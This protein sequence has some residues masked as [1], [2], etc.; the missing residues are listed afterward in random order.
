MS[1]PILFSWQALKRMRGGVQISRK[2][3]YI[4]GF[5]IVILANVSGSV[6]QLIICA[7]GVT[8][9][10]YFPLNKTSVPI[11]TTRYCCLTVE[12]DDA[13]S[14]LNIYNPNIGE[15]EVRNVDAT[16]TY[17]K[18]INKFNELTLEAL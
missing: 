13:R 4:G 8:Q 9:S 15:V 2:T 6:I 11:R 3:L 1:T 17:T 5:L 10:F 16:L 14:R 7:F 12:G 18:D